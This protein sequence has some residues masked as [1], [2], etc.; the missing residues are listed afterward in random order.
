MEGA[1]QFQDRAV[2]YPRGRLGRVV[3]PPH[4]MA[5]ELL[6]WR[7]ALLLVIRFARI[8]VGKP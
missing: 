5:H 3:V 1:R 6:G 4:F 7:V 8:N 2:R